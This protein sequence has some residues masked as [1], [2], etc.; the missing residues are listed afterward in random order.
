MRSKGSA[1]SLKGLVD[2]RNALF[3]VV[4]VMPALTCNR[5]FVYD[6]EAIGINKRLHAGKSQKNK[7]EQLGK[8]NP[9]V[10]RAVKE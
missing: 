4:I 6:I 9:G 2:V 8:G 7:I 3:R 10:R 5:V 1:D